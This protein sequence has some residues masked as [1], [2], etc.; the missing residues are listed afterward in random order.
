ME[1]EK[2]L[3][4]KRS[5]LSPVALLS[6]IGALAVGL[7]ILVILAGKGWKVI[8]ALD[9]TS[10]QPTNTMIQPV[11]EVSDNLKKEGILGALKSFEIDASNFVFTPNQIMVNEGDTVQINFTNSQGIHNF[12]IE[13]LNVQT[14]TIQKGESEQVTFTAGK[15][16]TYNF[17]CKVGNHAAMGM[18]GTLIV[19]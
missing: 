14:K 15:K 6:I 19:N 17:T 10:P 12:T 3:K 13:G 1:D 11:T 5:S 4:S 8:E 16:G 9:M 7:G 2:N 18:S